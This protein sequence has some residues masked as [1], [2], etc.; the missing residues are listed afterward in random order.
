MTLDPIPWAKPLIDREERESLLSCFTADWLTMGPK[1]AELE[2]R[3]ARR[4]QMP[5]AVAV[6]NGSVALD[7]ALKALKLQAGDE[8]LL[9]AMTY[10]A[11]AAAVNWQGAVPVFVDI[12]P[13]SWNLDPGR[14]AEAVTQRTRGVVYIDYGGNPADAPAIR[15]EAA[16]LGL[17]VLHDGAQSLGATV[18]GVPCG[19]DDVISSLSFHMAKVITTVEGGMLFC[20]EEGLAAELRARRSQGEY[21]GH[22]YIHEVLGTNARLTDLAAAIGLA[23]LDRL[24]AVLEQRRLASLWYTDRLRELAPLGLRTLEPGTL[25]RNA[26][27]LYSVRLPH[28]DRVAEN[29]KTLH[30]IETRIAYP[31]PLYRQPVYA[32]GR[33]ACRHMACPHSEALAAEVLNLPLFPGITEEQ[34]ER[35]V[36]A[37]ELEL[38][39][40]AGNPA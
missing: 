39:A 16:R 9:P 10:F 28:R 5:H 31:L 30:A 40:L 24:D 20:H 3:M 22:K 25:G 19:R 21:P 14:L 1:V 4:M 38:R 17:W 18:G 26:W 7:L 36:R 29:L 33:A 27:F 12:D 32:L 11:S 34:Q 15:A 23:Q 6:S 13:F 2:S 37:L 35:V 8:V